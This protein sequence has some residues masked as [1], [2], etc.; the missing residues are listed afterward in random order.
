MSS[1]EMTESDAVKQTETG[2][3]II[4]KKLNINKSS[5]SLK[6]PEDLEVHLRVLLLHILSI[7]TQKIWYWIK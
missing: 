2:H 5:K 7:T 6:M 4:F 3:Q 1:S